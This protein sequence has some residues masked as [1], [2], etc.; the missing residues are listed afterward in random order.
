MTILNDQF[1][2]INITFFSYVQRISLVKK[3]YS[4]LEKTDHQSLVQSD[5]WVE[6][7]FDFSKLMNSMFEKQF[8]I[9]EYVIHRN[10]NQ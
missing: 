6:R 7:T 2:C 1:E 9:N 3:K 5:E 10:V 8:G 4:R